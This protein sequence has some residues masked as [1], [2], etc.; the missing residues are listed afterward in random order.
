[1]EL[2]STP[3]GQFHSGSSRL[4]AGLELI[5]SKFGKSPCPSG[6]NSDC[7]G[8]SQAS[9]VWSAAVLDAAGDDP[10]PVTPCLD[11]LGW[12]ITRLAGQTLLR[13]R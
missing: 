11:F 10:V 5:N 4:A 1:V 7:A 6:I 8:A 12:S 3:T 13:R 2:Q 9:A